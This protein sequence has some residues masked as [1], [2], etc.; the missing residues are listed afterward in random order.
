MY[1][2]LILF[3]AKNPDWVSAKKLMGDTLFLQKLTN[4]DKENVSDRI[5]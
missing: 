5:I 3:G 4:Y 1:A 2:V